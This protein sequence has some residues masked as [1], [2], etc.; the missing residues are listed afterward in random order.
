MKNVI[1]LFL[2]LSLGCTKEKNPPS[3]GGGL[4]NPTD[5]GSGTANGCRISKSVS[6]TSSITYTADA[7]GKVIEAVQVSNGQLG[8]VTTYEY[9]GEVL[10]K[11]TNYTDAAKTQ[12]NSQTVY[13]KNANE[14][15][16]SGYHM[17]NGQLTEY[18]RTIYVMTSGKLT[19]IRS[20]SIQD[21]QETH[22]G[23]AFIETDANGNILEYAS[24]PYT[25]FYTYDSKINYQLAYPTATVLPIGKNN[26][27]TYVSKDANG[28]VQS[29]YN[30]N[31]TYNAQGLPISTS[32]QTTYEYRCK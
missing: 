14:V 31:Y 17:N 21:G 3:T 25:V 1:L 2:L 30:Y 22:L 7:S 9:S 4:K 19:E 28:V 16:I 29:S 15:V 26:P 20:Y 8:S 32:G 27:L 6:G 5:G 13:T 24:G 23:T 10:H 11:S 12:F 18:S